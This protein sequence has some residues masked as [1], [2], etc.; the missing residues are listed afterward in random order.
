[1]TWLESLFIVVGVGVRP[2][3]GGGGGWLDAIAVMGT[4]VGA[5]VLCVRFFE[6]LALRQ[7]LDRWL[8]ELLDDRPD[9]PDPPES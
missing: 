2:P 7:E 9:H 4:L 3:D 1:M 6:R 8:G 5:F